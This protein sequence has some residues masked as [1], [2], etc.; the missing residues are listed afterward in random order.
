MNGLSTLKVLDHKAQTEAKLGSVVVTENQAFFISISLGEIKHE[1]KS[2]FA[3]STQS[4][5]Y[6]ELNGKKAGDSLTFRGKSTKI[7]SVF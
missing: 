5:I 2:Y 3:I 1:G 6:Q 4:P 7:I